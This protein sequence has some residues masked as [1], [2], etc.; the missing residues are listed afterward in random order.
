MSFTSS[1]YGDVQGSY[2]CIL[3]KLASTKKG[4]IHECVASAI[5]S[6]KVNRIWA[7]M[8][9]NIGD[10]KAMVTLKNPSESGLFPEVSS[11]ILTSVDDKIIAQMII[12][13]ERRLAEIKYGSKRVKASFDE[14]Y[15]Q[16][17]LGILN[18]PTNINEFN[19]AE[20]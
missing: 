2:A 13:R 17:E 8:K 15:V 4:G 20:S 12:D 7:P 6:P 10:Q 9:F 16:L 18:M 14:K 5:V 19:N 1:M 3:G 11:I